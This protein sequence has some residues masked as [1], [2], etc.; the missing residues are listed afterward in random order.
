ME[1][2]NRFTNSVHVV[3]QQFRK[4]SLGSKKASNKITINCFRYSSALMPLSRRIRPFADKY[5]P[6]GKIF[7]Y[8]IEAKAEFAKQYKCSA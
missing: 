2:E 4:Q 7:K 6:R 3:F 8:E 5:L 1:K